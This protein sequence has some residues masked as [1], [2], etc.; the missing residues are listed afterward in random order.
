VVLIHG[1][2][3]HP[4]KTWLYEST[5]FSRF[6]RKPGS[7]YW[8]EDLLPKDFPK[9]RIITYGYD[10][11]T[12]H[13]FSGTAN[14]TNILGHA[15]A[16]IEEF[17]GLRQA[18]PRRPLVFVAHSLGGLLLKAILS[19]TSEAENSL[20]N[21]IVYDIFTS[22]V[23]TIFLGTPHRGSDYAQ[24]GQIV[25]LAAKTLQ[26]DSTTSLLRD[27]KVDASVLELLNGSFI[28]LATRQNFTIVTFEEGRALGVPL[29]ARDKVVP[30][31]SAHLGLDD[32]TEHKNVINAD[33][34]KMC[35]FEGAESAGYGKVKRAIERCLRDRD[36]NILDFEFS[37]ALRNLYTPETSLRYES[38]ERRY[39][40]TYEWIFTDESLGFK[41]WLESA[42]PFF[43]IK[44]KPASGKST[45]M[46]MISNDKRVSSVLKRQDQK[47]SI[48][49]YFFHDRGSQ[50]QKTLQGLMREILH[51]ILSDIPELRS[52]FL[53]AYRRSS[54]Y[55]L[56]GSKFEW[57]LRT[58]IPLYRDILQQN[59][60]NASIILFI[61]ALDEYSGNYA[62]I[63][64]FLRE[65]NGIN[66]T[67]L[68]IC[69]SSRPE[70]L[71]LD[72][73][74]HL[75]GFYIH[76][77]TKS[78]IREVIE[79]TFRENPRIQRDTQSGSPLEKNK[80]LHIQAEIARLAEGVF[81]WVRLIVDEIL[82]EHTNGASIDELLDL[83]HS[84]P[85]ELESYYDHIMAN[86]INKKYAAEREAM[87]EILL[88]AVR[89]LTVKEL[90]V[91]LQLIPVTDLKNFSVSLP[92]LEEA[93]RR[94]KSRC[95]SL[96]ELQFVNKS[97]RTDYDHPLDNFYVQFLH[98]TVK[99]WSGKNSQANGRFHNENGYSFLIK[100]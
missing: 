84:V 5:S 57:G 62:D 14:Q 75:P 45:L 86:R 71:L 26:V 67:H 2:Q 69:F 31:W 92:S 70:Q 98:Q 76:D 74:I 52:L 42:E 16:F 63:V 11:H 28:R 95:G 97:G 13:F 61:D 83:L 94:I 10:S 88:S 33:H 100:M 36:A 17:E 15:R 37:Q 41:A 77:R 7:C 90:F 18:V 51:T 99:T 65:S 54:S 44:G 53:K 66:K 79:A 4:K 29:L 68:K 12:S 60:V 3:G 21:Q 80:I 49:A 40:N 25:A 93:R 56:S 82:N 24:M 48:A 73:F 50:L 1:L 72:S 23:G 20:S 89:R 55:F 32:E 58:T 59:I 81:L 38:I 9:I 6:K 87:F 39:S 8:P 43:W 78:D 96:V 47:I 22:T 34:R 46:K 91:T 64:K 85:R 30:H 19:Q 35:R 27:M